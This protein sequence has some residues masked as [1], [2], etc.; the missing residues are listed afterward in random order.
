[1]EHQQTESIQADDYERQESRTSPR[2]GD[3]DRDYTPRGGTHGLNAGAF[4]NLQWLP[5]IKVVSFKH[6]SCPFQTIRYTA[7]CST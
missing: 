7:A 5:Q 2:N 3:Y 1:M 4:T 6:L